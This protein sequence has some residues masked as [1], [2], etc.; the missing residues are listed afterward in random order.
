MGL[1]DSY[2]AKVKVSAVDFR[3]LAETDRESA[4]GDEHRIGGR[5][6]WDKKTPVIELPQVVLDD[7]AEYLR[8]RGT[9]AASVGDTETPG[10][11]EAA[12]A[13]RKGRAPLERA[14]EAVR[15]I[16]H[17]LYH[18]WREKEGHSDNPLQA[19]FEKEAKARMAKVRDNWVAYL[20]DLPAVSLR[21]EGI[22]AGTVIKKWTDIPEAVRNS[23][24]EGAAKTDYIAGLYQR[25]AYLVEEI[26]TKIEELSYL[27]VQQRDKTAA[28]YEPSKSEVSG[29][30]TLVN[31]LHN[32]LSSMADPDGLIT[33]DLLAKT[34]TAM[35]K[36]LR[37]R[38]KS[39]AGAD[40]DAYE[41][42]F[43]LSAVRSGLPPH[44]SGDKLIS[45]VPGA[46]LPP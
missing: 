45:N 20:K 33:P 7:V 31:Y 9:P 32:V 29:L 25:S 10:S 2:A 23:I 39:P 1:W 17:E 34:E 8:V 15:V 18:L 35:L 44:Y 30:A 12:A 16:G 40:Y 3:L 14:H 46:R 4:F 13:V 19:P 21:A 11:S 5:S 24:E 37:D 22:P 28:I 43:Y 6:F 36:H 41:V 26:Y 38:F 27:R 42:V